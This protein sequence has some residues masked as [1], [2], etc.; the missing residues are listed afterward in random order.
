MGCVWLCPGGMEGSLSGPCS[1]PS[2]SVPLATNL[3]KFRMEQ[4]IS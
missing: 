4:N 1:V 2:S 3:G